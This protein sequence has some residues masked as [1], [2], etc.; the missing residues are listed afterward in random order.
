M[1]SKHQ[2]SLEVP[3]TNNPKVFRI[4]DTSIYS[5]LLDI[6]CGVLSITPPGFNEPVNFNVDPH[7]NLI[8][9]ACSLGLQTI[10]CGFDSDQLPDG[11]YTIRYSV[12]PNDKV[13]VEYLY[14]RQTRVLNRYFHELCEIE[15]AACDPLPDIKDELKELY[16]IKSFLDAAKAKVE[17]CESHLQGMDLMNYADRRLLK[18]EGRSC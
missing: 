12:S 16:L 2:L 1:P 13:Y 18:F 11:I 6:T 17:V 15:L 14:L 9:S 4:F 10:G 3:D 5:D 8:L 7:F